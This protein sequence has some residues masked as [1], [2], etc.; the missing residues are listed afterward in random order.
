MP[1]AADCEPG[2]CQV[3]PQGYGAVMLRV[4]LRICLPLL[5]F[6]CPA[7]EPDPGPEAKRE[8]IHAAVRGQ[9]EA[10]RKGDFAAAYQFAAPNIQAQFPLPEF[11]TMVR[12]GYPVIARNV[13]AIFGLTLEDGSRAAVTVRVIGP[14]QLTVAFRYMLEFI[15]GRWRI[16][17]VQ[18]AGEKSDPI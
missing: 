7:A 1:L 3:P 10:F 5:A 12:R 18:E 11:E 13:D 4:L 17:G 15:E 2:I 14:G 8:A 16:V 9:L 6:V